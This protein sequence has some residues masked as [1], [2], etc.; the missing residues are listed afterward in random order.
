MNKIPLVLYS[1]GLDSTNL[2]YALLQEGDVDVFYVSGQQSPT[3]IAA[4][5]A[6]RQRAKR[7][8]YEEHV[9]GQLK[10]RIISDFS[11]EIGRTF[12][13]APD[14]ALVQPIT[15][16]TAAFHV[17][18]P[19]R[20]SAL[21]VG[22]IAGDAALAE[23]EHMVGFWQHGW[24][25]L[26]W[27]RQKAPPLETMFS[28]R[29]WDK[30]EM[31]RIL[32]EGL[33]PHIWVCEKPHV[34]MRRGEEHPKAC[35]RCKPCRTMRHAMADFEEYHG[36]PYVTCYRRHLKNLRRV[37]ALLKQQGAPEVDHIPEVWLPTRVITP[38]DL[39]PKVPEFQ[40]E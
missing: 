23:R 33:I 32:P 28:D 8:F 26:H 20:H 4:E 21:H 34:K 39:E 7:W 40:D 2:V 16:L 31:L 17:C 1:G 22:Y 9:N 10:G 35:M 18:D 11:A 12:V 14:A 29:G 13:D 5:K 15:W 36:M 24:R 30:L 25:L 6:A 19:K 27:R 3:K 37:N 38:E